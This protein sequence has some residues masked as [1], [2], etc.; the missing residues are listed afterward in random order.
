[1]RLALS[2]RRLPDMPHRRLW[3]VP[4]LLRE[5]IRFLD[6]VAEDFILV[7][8]LNDGYA[9][10]L[11][12][13]HRQ[14]PDRKIIGFWDRKGAPE[15]TRLGENLVFHQ[16]DDRAFLNAMGRCVGLVTTAGFES[17]CEA[18]YLGKP[19]FMMPTGNQIEQ[20]C[21]ALDA[22]LAGAGIWDCCFDLDRFME[23]IPHHNPNLKGFRSWVDSAE[24][25]CIGLFKLLEA[26]SYYQ[27]H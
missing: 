16:L 14:H 21:N 5:D 26:S 18:M 7:Y 2:F 4:P 3:I 8:V 24:E 25:H 9:D 6:S 15:T 19:V 13:W 20:H 17:V 1:M 23:Y 22:C 10:D 27:E 12:R 11:A